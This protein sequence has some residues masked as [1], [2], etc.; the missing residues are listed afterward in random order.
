[1][2]RIAIDGSTLIVNRRDQRLVNRKFY[3]F[4]A[5][6]G[7]AT[8][9]RY[10]TDPQRFVPYSTDPDEEPIYPD[11]EAHRGWKVFGR[12]VRVITDI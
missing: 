11:V 9:K 2:D 3:V 1:M 6:D 4:V 10:R 12:V 7:E 5:T 8:F